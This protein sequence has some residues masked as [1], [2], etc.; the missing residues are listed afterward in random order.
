M[1]LPG[2]HREKK[3][4]QEIVEPVVEQAPEPQAEFLQEIK[5]PTHE[6]VFVEEKPKRR[7]RSKKS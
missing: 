7:R 2:S 3:V 1:P 6:E 4:L 5:E